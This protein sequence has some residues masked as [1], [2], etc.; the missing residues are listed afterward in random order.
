MTDIVLHHRNGTA[1]PITALPTPESALVATARREVFDGLNFDAISHGIEESGGM[2]Y[3]AYN[4]VAGF[5][6]LQ[7]SMSTLH[8]QYA[9]LCIR[10]EASM[11]SFAD[12]SGGVQRKLKAIVRYLYL[13]ESDAA[14]AATNTLAGV[15][16]RMHENAG[17]MRRHVEEVADNATAILADVHVA[18]AE[19]DM[20]VRKSREQ[21]QD[22]EASNERAKVV[23]QQVTNSMDEL[24]KLQKAIERKLE[25]T[26]QRAFSM[27]V[28]GAI[29]GPIAQGVGAFA[30]MYSGG[31]VAGAVN[32]VG[33]A[34]KPPAAVPGEA[35]SNAAEEFKQD[36][37]GKKKE[38]EEARQSVAKAEDAL[39]KQ[40][41]ALDLASAGASQGGADPAPSA[42]PGKDDSAESAGAKD[43]G[44]AAPKTKAQSATGAPE[45]ASAKPAGDSGQVRA[46]GPALAEH[47]LATAKRE[48][49]R[50]KAAHKQA[51][52]EL[53]TLEAQQTKLRLAAVASGVS[54]AAGATEQAANKG[55]DGLYGLIDNYNARLNTLF[56]QQQENEIVK[57][58]SIAQMAEYALRIKNMNAAEADVTVARNSLTIAIAALKR[59]AT[60]LFHLQEFWI[61]MES[62]CK[63]LQVHNVMSKVLEEFPGLKDMQ[64]V[65]SVD[66]DF[67]SDMVDLY[68]RWSAI[69]QVCRQLALDTMTTKQQ[70]IE[71]FKTA[72]PIAERRKLA[73]QLGASLLSSLN[74]QLRRSEDRTRL[75]ADQRGALAQACR[76]PASETV[77]LEA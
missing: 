62:Q 46:A 3:L 42:A 76:A 35:A 39:A 41:L 2:I 52:E 60:A 64:L 1:Y 40:S 49:E 16:A 45:K 9:K 69:E 8:G 70:V 11:R 5:P 32:A 43:A 7:G 73:I 33:G 63:S 55:A 10:S 30:S 20:A 59:V 71:D 67:Q 31:A 68:C 24:G 75:L 61:K 72:L 50:A 58:E 66:E 23:A 19:T 74:E 22:I 12:E 15:A 38:L 13:N 44:A 29:M 21:I 4:G 51:G 17:A 37:A 34:M 47:D 48:L 25:T 14:V 53:K 18:E 77:A 26:E 28:V 65:L 36:I 6:K 27:S 54:A 56:Q 57:R